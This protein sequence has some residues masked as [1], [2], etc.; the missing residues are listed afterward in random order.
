MLSPSHRSRH[1]E[2]Y[3]LCANS[4]SNVSRMCLFLRCLHLYM[5]SP[6]SQPL[7]LSSHSGAF[8]F[9]ASATRTAAIRLKYCIMA[10]TFGSPRKSAPAQSFARRV[11]LKASRAA[12][13]P[14][15]NRMGGGTAAVKFIEDNQ[16]FFLPKPA[17]TLHLHIQ[18]F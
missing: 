4:F 11:G 6:F 10:I 9:I 17:S 7:T 3:G 2:L 18:D 1:Q 8:P 5:N 12:I 14:E 15:R 13:Y 16:I